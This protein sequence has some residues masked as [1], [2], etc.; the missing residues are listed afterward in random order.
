[1]G[2]APARGVD[3]RRGRD[4]CDARPARAAVRERQEGSG[5]DGHDRFARHAEQQV[6]G[7]RGAVGRQ[8]ARAGAARRRLHQPPGRAQPLRARARRARQPVEAGL[9]APRHAGPGPSGAA[10]PAG[11]PHRAVRGG[12]R[13]DTRAR[14]GGGQRRRHAGA[15][16]AAGRPGPRGRRTPQGTARQ[17]R[18]RGGGRH[19]RQRP[20]AAFHEDF[21]EAPARPVEAR[22]GHQRQRAGG[23]PQRLRHRQ[24]CLE[25][26]ADDHRD[27]SG[28][29]Q[30]RRRQGGER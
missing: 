12:G 30:V 20:S 1:M 4:R 2:D 18:R 16:E 24:V 10:V 3:D 19:Q 14:A 27:A 11:H 6:R 22:D 15:E 25:V 26:D 13:R 5:R 29:R 21:Q 7:R 8:G 23:P 28:V 9:A 17:G